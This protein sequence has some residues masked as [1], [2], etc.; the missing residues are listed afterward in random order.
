MKA[1]SIPVIQ[2]P[3]NVGETSHTI[4]GKYILFIDVKYDDS[5]ENP[6]KDWDGVGSIRSLS[7]RHIDSIDYAEAKELLETDKDVVALSYYEH[8]NSLWMV[9]A[10]PAPAGV[11]F[12]WDGVRF[13]GVWIPDKSV[14]ESYIK[15]DGLTRRDWMVKQ[16]DA[17]CKT[18]TDFCNGY[19]YGYNVQ[20]HK[21]RKENGNE[22]TGFS[23]YRFSEALFD[24][25]CWGFYGWDY[26]KSQVLEAVSSA[27][28][29]LHFSKRSIK[30]A[31]KTV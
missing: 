21:L 13:A 9:A 28:E 3:D 16:A 15:Q 20:L 22:Y 29:Q 23:D 27:L 5:S 2:F 8:G 1:K 19:V 26:F 18:Y 4:I 12:Q 11:E 10:L 30:N 6:C 17:A 14:R 31:L 24:D 7:R 25:S